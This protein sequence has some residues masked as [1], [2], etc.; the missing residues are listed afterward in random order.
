MTRYSPL[1]NQIC[2]KDLERKLKLILS[3]SPLPFPIKH[4]LPNNVF[5]FPFLVRTRG[6]LFCFI[7]FCGKWLFY[8]YLILPLLV[9]QLNSMLSTLY[10]LITTFIVVFGRGLCNKCLM[11][12]HQ[13]HWVRSSFFKMYLLLDESRIFEVDP[14]MAFVKGFMS[15]TFSL[16]S[17]FALFVFHATSFI[18]QNRKELKLVKVKRKIGERKHTL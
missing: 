10:S 4:C 8:F 2:W 14:V 6:L 12:L 5:L 18:V 13:F 11:W 7:P 16:D 17:S 3:F 9:C 1:V 15:T